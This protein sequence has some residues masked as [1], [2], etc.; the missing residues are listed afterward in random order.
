MSPKKTSALPI[1]NHSTQK[2]MLRA[3]F[4]GAL[5]RVSKHTQT[6][7]DGSIGV[8]VG[9]TI[10]PKREKNEDR[11]CA[12][13]ISKGIARS[14][15]LFV[16]VVCDGIGGE[17]HGEES[18]WKAAAA[19]LTQCALSK[20][21]DPIEILRGAVLDA[22]RVV[23][24]L[25]QGLG[26][27]TL[28]ALLVTGDG[29]MGAVNCGDSRVYK[30][31]PSGKIEQLSHDQT[32]GAAIGGLGQMSPANDFLKAYDRELGNFIGIG[33]D[34]S[35][36]FI[37]ISRALPG[38]QII[39]STDGAWGALGPL[40]ETIFTAA[41]SATE[42]VKRVLAAVNYAAGGDNASLAVVSLD[43]TLLTALRTNKGKEGLIE[44]NGISPN[45]EL[46]L[47]SAIAENKPP[48]DEYVP[49]SAISPYT[50][51]G[52]Q[53]KKSTRPKQS[54][55]PLEQDGSETQKENARKR[56]AV[57]RVRVVA[58][59]DKDGNGEDEAN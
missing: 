47:S 50:R 8:V 31:T 3:A 39:L 33:P 21:N 11:V 20:S 17:R 41:P 37:E 40:F 45:G 58:L 23:Y 52:G 1:V 25:T 10:G 5:Q 19:F 51:R 42:S 27:T 16:A 26:G 2:D 24:P 48:I 35:P 55:L 56:K 43:D 30:T 57:P 9:T 14:D 4:E 18:A 53:R 22:D 6:V 38:G 49:R 28:V 34:I 44:I 54:P 13:R 29:G 32:I 7:E 46:Y 59:G 12:V 15:Q 36:E